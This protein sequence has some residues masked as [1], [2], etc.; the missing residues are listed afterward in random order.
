MSSLKRKCSENIVL[1]YT[2]HRIW[3][4]CVGE[5]MRINLCVFTDEC[6]YV[7]VIA[8]V[9]TH[10]N[11]Q[12]EQAFGVAVCR[13]SVCFYFFFPPSSHFSLGLFM[14]S[15]LQGRLRVVRRWER[16]LLIYTQESHLLHGYVLC[17]EAWR[18]VLHWG[19]HSLCWL[20]LWWL[21]RELFRETERDLDPPNRI[22]F[23]CEYRSQ[24][25]LAQTYAW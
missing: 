11:V 17:E 10:V 23:T 18:L 16:G 15:G 22:T 21:P 14:M 20:F 7:C 2:H 1:W 12:I 6:V 8:H 9:W 13:T 5:C 19:C 4:I 24:P 3:C 25:A